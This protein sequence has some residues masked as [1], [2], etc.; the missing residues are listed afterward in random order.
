MQTIPLLSPHPPLVRNDLQNI[1]EI[2][3]RALNSLMKEGQLS[4]V[5]TSSQQTK[6]PVEQIHPQ[7]PLRKPHPT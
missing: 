3:F 5:P 7:S 1:S 6:V 2:H 4:S